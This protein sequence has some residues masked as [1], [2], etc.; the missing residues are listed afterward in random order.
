MFLNRVID[1]LGFILRAE[2]RQKF[3]L[4]F[5]HAEFIEGA[6]DIVGN[7]FPGFLAFLHRLDVVENILQIQRRKIGSPSWHGPLEKM[8]ERLQAEV[9]HPLRLA[10][11]ARDIFHNLTAQ[12]S[13]RFKRVVIIA[14]VEAIFIF[15]DPFQDLFILFL[16]THKNS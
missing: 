14:V 16:F 13:F 10:F 9:E 5:R 3:T 4:R 11:H 1:H 15:A 2:S 7:I 8:I 6:L 12:T